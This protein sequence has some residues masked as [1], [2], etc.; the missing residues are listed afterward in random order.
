MKRFVILIFLLLL[1]THSAFAK[2]AMSSEILAYQQGRYDEARLVYQ[3][4]LEQHPYSSEALYNLGNIYFKQG[5]WGEALTYYCRARRLAP[6]DGDIA[7]NTQLVESQLKERVSLSPFSVAFAEKLTRWVSVDESAILFFL[8]AMLFLFFVGIMVFKKKSASEFKGRFVFFGG[9]AFVLGL[10]FFLKCL[11]DVWPNYAIIIDR[12]TEIKSG[13]SGQL[14][15]QGYVYE[16][17]K[18]RVIKMEGHWANV[19]VQNGVQGWII[20]ESFWEL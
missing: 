2:G 12:K 11:G 16:G 13:P 8:P 10:L 14:A 6:R 20:R 17:A 7:F 5:E 3:T 18:L 4:Y 15:T 9:A 19:E 1:G